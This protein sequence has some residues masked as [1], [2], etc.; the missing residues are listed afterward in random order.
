MRVKEF[1]EKSDQAW[2]TAKESIL[3]ADVF[4]VVSIFFVAV[5]FFTL[6]LMTTF[7]EEDDYH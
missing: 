4:T 2:N 5:V 6:F 1:L 7:N 3:N